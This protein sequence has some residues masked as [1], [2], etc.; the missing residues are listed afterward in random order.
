MALAVLKLMEI[1]CPA[2]YLLTFEATVI[3]LE[4]QFLHL[5]QLAALQHLLFHWS[6]PWIMKSPLFQGR[7]LL[8]LN[9]DDL[10]HLFSPKCLL[11]SALL[12]CLKFSTLV[13]LELN[14]LLQGFLSI[15]CVAGFKLHLCFSEIAAFRPTSIHAPLSAKLSSFTLQ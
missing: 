11:F 1:P 10:F 2:L 8:N 6:H 9:F 5:L 14:Y 13:W 7:N 3:S 12:Q 4:I 15:F